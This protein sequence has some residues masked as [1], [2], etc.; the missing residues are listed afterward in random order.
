MNRTLLLLL[1]PFGLFAQEA[2]VAFVE[3]PFDELLAQAR[4]EDK[5]IFIDAYTTWCGPCKMMTA[6]VFPQPEVGEVYNSRFINAKF[7]ME[8]GEGPGL[9]E[10]YGVNA[11]PTYLF[12]NGDGELVHKGLGYIPAP[13]LLE[14]ADVAV[15]D[16][17][18]G[19]LEARFEAGERDGEFL[20][21]FA[22][23]LAAAN[24]GVRADRIVTAYL[25]EQDDWSTP[26]NLRLL[27]TSPGPVGDA[28]MHYIAEHAAEIEKTLGAGSATG[29]LQS[30]LINTYH[31]SHRK[32]SLVAPE[33]IEAF[34]RAEG[35]PMWEQ[36]HS[37]YA[38][39]YYRQKRDMKRYLPM[40]LVHYE[41]YPDA[42]FTELNGVAWAFYEHSD[43]PAELA[44]AI[45]WAEKS[46]ELNPYYPNLDT[47]AWLYHK[48]GQQDKAE[49]AAR[50][51]ITYA[52]EAGLD[53]AETQKIFQ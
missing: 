52:K 48:T 19:A 31:R 28:R 47:L 21:T 5:L 30:N 24:D 36:L 42:S 22:E 11:Y 1:L 25:D 45:A 51:A 2:G 27:L 32:R 53:Y 13:A 10:R 20:S 8:Q 41:K 3:R 17:S 44:Q 33:E 50:R 34:Y 39:N 15:S 12:V 26:A 38:L 23:A 43:D 16:R 49:A 4:T 7:D 37:A 40:A 18:L 29:V 14:L 9:A 46:V 35:G 6:Q